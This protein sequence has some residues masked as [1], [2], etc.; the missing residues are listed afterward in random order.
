MQVIPCKNA[1][2]VVE[3]QNDES[4]LRVLHICN[5]HKKLSAVPQRW[6]FSQ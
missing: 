1:I 5:K 4:D 2:S 3:K 6:Q